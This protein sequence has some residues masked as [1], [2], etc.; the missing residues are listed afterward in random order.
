MGISKPNDSRIMLMLYFTIPPRIGEDFVKFLESCR[1]YPALS[2]PRNRYFFLYGEVQLSTLPGAS[3]WFSSQ[4]LG[5]V[6]INHTLKASLDSRTGFC[7]TGLQLE[8]RQVIYSLR[9]PVNIV[10]VSHFYCRVL[11]SEWT[12]DP[13]KQLPRIGIKGIGDITN[14]SCCRCR[15]GANAACVCSS[16]V[17]LHTAVSIVRKPLLT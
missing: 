5:F 4:N 16:K 10:D 11:V 9:V 8:E 17:K 2:T 1:H 7:K 3:S 13:K 15:F 14:V 6:T 12:P